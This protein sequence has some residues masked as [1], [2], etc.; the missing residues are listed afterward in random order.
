MD[1]ENDEAADHKEQID[2]DVT[3]MKQPAEDRLMSILLCAD[4]LRGVVQENQKTRARAR[5]LN[6]S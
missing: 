1:L 2:A 6:R 5:C 3:E 4:D